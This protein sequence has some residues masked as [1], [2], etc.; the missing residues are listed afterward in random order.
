MADATCSEEGCDRPVLARGLCSRDYQRWRARRPADWHEPPREKPGCLAGDC[1]RTA[2]ARGY[3]NRHYENLRRY[4][5]PIPQRDRALEVRLREVGWTVTASGCWEW[6]GSRN[7]NGYGLFSASRLGY[8]NTRAHRV[9]YECLVEPVP[10]HLVL[11]HK[12]DNPPCVNPGHLIP[13]TSLDNSRDM[14]ERER[15]W[16]H[17]RTSCDN[18]HDLV[19]PG[20]LRRVSKKDGT[21]YWMQRLPGLRNSIGTA[22]PRPSRARACFCVPGR[23][24][25]GG[26]SLLAFVAPRG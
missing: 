7:D 20:A 2:R 6:N 15:H 23:R 22:G 4:G 12:C 10:D 5:E 19:I 13:G 25:P 9:V 16:R 14:V 21:E 8:E 26:R 11:R 1:P 18:G 24:L 3:C 17:G